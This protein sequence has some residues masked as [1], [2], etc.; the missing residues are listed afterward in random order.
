VYS[1]VPASMVGREQEIE[2]GP[3]SGRSNVIYW[4][5]RRGLRRPMSE[6][7]ASWRRRKR[8]NGDRRRNPGCAA[9]DVT[10]SFAD[11]DRR[12]AGAAGLIVADIL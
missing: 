3:M 8:V 11:R 7:T 9:N 12:R 4:L 6:W 1:G 2:V 5:E 10:G